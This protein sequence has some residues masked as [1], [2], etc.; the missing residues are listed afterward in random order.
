[1]V[2]YSEKNK[3]FDVESYVVNL[4]EDNGFSVRVVDSY[5]D[6]EVYKNGVTQY[7]EIKSC[8]FQV[9]NGKNK[10]MYGRFDFTN[11]SNRERQYKEKLIICFVVVMGEEMNFMGLLNARNLY[12]R[13]YI[14]LG[15]V[16]TRKRCLS[17]QEYETRYH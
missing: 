11:K 17:L 5:Y 16:M 14:P 10:K 15:E 1:M 4:F 7:I 12:K 9:S 2:G 8:N 6:L 3:G 13:R